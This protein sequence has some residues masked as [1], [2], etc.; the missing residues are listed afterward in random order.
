MF[1]AESMAKAFIGVFHSPI[2]FQIDPSSFEK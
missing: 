1:S 2:F